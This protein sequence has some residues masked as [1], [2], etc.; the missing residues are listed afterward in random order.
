MVGTLCLVSQ[1]KEQLCLNYDEFL[2]ERI[3]SQLENFHNLGNIFRY[4]TFLMLIIINS[5]LQTLPQMEPEFFA[6]NVNLSERNSSMTFFNFTDKIMASIYRLIFGT[7]LPRLTE[8]MK[9]CLHNSN[10]PVAD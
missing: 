5:N 4:Q 10:E 7:T 6:D 9:A 3:G 8:E 2:V 1:S